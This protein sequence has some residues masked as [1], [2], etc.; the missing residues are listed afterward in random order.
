MEMFE[1]FRS[2]VNPLELYV[3]PSL[4]QKRTIVSILYRDGVTLENFQGPKSVT[5]SF[6]SVNEADYIVFHSKKGVIG[7]LSRAALLKP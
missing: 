7:K 1:H 5:L 6:T 2:S 4:P 3:V